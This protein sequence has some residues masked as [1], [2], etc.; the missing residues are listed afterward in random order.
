MISEEIYVRLS[1]LG[2]RRAQIVNNIELALFAALCIGAFIG[3]MY[4]GGW[5]CEV[6]F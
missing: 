5:I 3:T 1:P 6:L 2:K 4:L